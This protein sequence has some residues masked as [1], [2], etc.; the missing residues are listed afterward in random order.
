ML[1]DAPFLIESRYLLIEDWRPLFTSVFREAASASS[2]TMKRG[3]PFINPVEAKTFAQSRRIRA[4][5]FRT[6]IT[7]SMSRFSMKRPESFSP[8]IQNPFKSALTRSSV[9]CWRTTLSVVSRT[10][11]G[12]PISAALQMMPNIW[13][14]FPDCTFPNNRPISWLQN[15]NRL[16]CRVPTSSAVLDMDSARRMFPRSVIVLR[17]VFRY[18]ITQ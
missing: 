10:K 15:E 8:Q 2:S 1:L 18:C 5:F 9:C 17:Y 4:F 6:M 3:F 14:V 7:G 12:K 16:I 13:P 11:A